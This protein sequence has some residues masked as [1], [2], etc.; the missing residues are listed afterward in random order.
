MPLGDGPGH[1]AFRDIVFAREIMC[2]SPE[3]DEEHAEELLRRELLYLASPLLLHRESL[4]GREFLWQYRRKLPF[5][6]SIP[7]K[8]HHRAPQ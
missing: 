7:P 8:L 4:L 3:V 5:H 2:E 1:Y 6:T